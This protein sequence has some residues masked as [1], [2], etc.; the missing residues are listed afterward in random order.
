MR[1]AGSSAGP[2]QSDILVLDKAQET[3]LVS[4]DHRGLQRRGRV[5]RGS[6]QNDLPTQSPTSF[7]PPTESRETVDVFRL[8]LAQKFYF[9]AAD[10]QASEMIPDSIEKHTIKNE[11]MAGQAEKG[12]VGPSRRTPDQAARSPCM[13]KHRPVLQHRERSYKQALC[14]SR[15]SQS[16]S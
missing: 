6:G 12:R 14:R 2:E 5:L 11:C 3:V 9:T 10:K 7:I 15:S 1:F 4:V 13:P 8:N 16:R